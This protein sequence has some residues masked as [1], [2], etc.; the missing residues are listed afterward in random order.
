MPVKGTLEF[1]GQTLD[2]DDTPRPTSGDR[3]RHDLPG[4]QPA[5]G[6]VGGRE[7]V[8]RPRAAAERPDRLGPDVQGRTSNHRRPRA[9]A[10]AA[11]AGAFAQRRRAADGRDLQGAHHERQAHHHGRADGGAQR[12]RGRQAA[13]DHPRSEGQGHQH[14]L[15]LAQAERGQGH[16]RSLHHLPRRQVHHQRQRGGCHDR[17]H[18][19][20]DGRARRR[21]P[22]KA[23]HRRA[24]RGRAEGAGRLPC[25]QRQRPARHRAARH[26]GRGPSRRDRR[27]CR[28]R[29]G[30]PDRARPG[31][32]RRRPLRRGDHLR[33][34]PAD[35]AASLA[36]GGDRRR[37]RAG[38]RGSEAAGLLS[39]PLDPAEHEPAQPG[40][41]H[42]VALLH[43]RAGRDA[44]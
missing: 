1:D 15:R 20:A 27:L 42:Q 40:S 9:R 12:P 44:G 39:H 19:P 31:D 16:L 4:V 18:R 23:T 38:A 5:A 8:S 30:R 41:A 36:Q 17:R 32:L 3:H 25:R 34:R 10:R 43:R 13:R 14:H 33:Q 24:G 22:E 7:H 2:R 6:D 26:V 11:D 37:H 28:P 21:I 29:R 35:F